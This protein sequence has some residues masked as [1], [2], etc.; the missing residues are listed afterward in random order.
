MTLLKFKKKKTVIRQ[1]RRY[2]IHSHLWANRP[3]GKKTDFPGRPLLKGP[4]PVLNVPICLLIILNI[5][6]FTSCL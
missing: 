5:T 1:T 2:V 4:T 6:V 3:I